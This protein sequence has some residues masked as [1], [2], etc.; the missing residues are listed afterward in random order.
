MCVCVC[1]LV[2]SEVSCKTMEGFDGLKKLMYT[3]VLSMKDG[4]SSACGG[5]LLGRLVSETVGLGSSTGTQTKYI[6]GTTLTFFR[7]RA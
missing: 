5:K 6:H 1:V 4:S 3:V 2:L 7:S